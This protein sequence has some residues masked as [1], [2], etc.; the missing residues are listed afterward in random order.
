LRFDGTDWNFSAEG[1]FA[2]FE[3]KLTGDFA[4]GIEITHGGRKQ[5]LCRGKEV[6]SGGISGRDR[7]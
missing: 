5:N 1:A 7:A 2:G 3:G 4:G 6:L